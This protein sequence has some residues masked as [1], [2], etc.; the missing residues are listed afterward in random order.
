MTAG[1]TIKVYAAVK[2]EMGINT[3][4][5]TPMQL[6]LNPEAIAAGIKL[7]AEG[8]VIQGNGSVPIDL[9][10]PKGITKQY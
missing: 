3:A 1:Q 4:N 5:G 6:T 7:S 2:D 9:I 10:V 8:V